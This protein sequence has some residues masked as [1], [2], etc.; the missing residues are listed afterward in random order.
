VRWLS[1]KQAVATL[2]RAHE[3]VFL[4]N[5]GPIALKAARQSARSKSAKRS[6]RNGGRRRGRSAPGAAAEHSAAAG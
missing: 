3:K 2:T 4:A 5:V 1:L 6:A